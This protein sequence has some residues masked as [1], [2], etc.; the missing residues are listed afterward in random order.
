MDLR[1]YGRVI[2]RYRELV[3]GGFA[4]AILLTFFAVFR[5]SSDGFEW[6]QDKTYQAT[7]KL[8]LTNLGGPNLD[9]GTAITLD[10]EIANSD[11]VRVQAF[12]NKSVEA[13]YLV[14]AIS[15]GSAIGP[16]PL[17]QIDGFASSPE[18]AS[19]IAADITDALQ[20]YLPANVAGNRRVSFS[21]LSTPDH[22]VVSQGRR[23]TVPI[24]IFLS[25]LVVTFGLAFLLENLSTRAPVAPRNRE[26]KPADETD[27]R[28]VSTPANDEGASRNGGDGEE[29]APKARQSARPR[30]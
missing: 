10:A 17:L 9:F 22:P 25:V 26:P 29:A 18:R 12:G 20:T 11:A 15:G 24:V 23:M 27:V 2:S 4:L 8:L 3:V 16:L 21:V 30:T 5:V 14:T 13:K 28:P 7:S 19:R 6:R 1:L